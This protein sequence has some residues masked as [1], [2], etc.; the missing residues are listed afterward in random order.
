MKFAVLALLGAVS[1]INLEHYNDAQGLAQREPS[2]TTKADRDLEKAKK[3]V[4]EKASRPRE[5]G[6]S[7]NDPVHIGGT[8]GQREG[9]INE[10]APTGNPTGQFPPVTI[11][12][13]VETDSNNGWQYSTTNRFKIK[14]AMDGGR[15]LYMSYE[16]EVG[17]HGVHTNQYRVYLRESEGNM[18]EFWY[19]NKNDQTIRS[20]AN[21]EYCLDWDHVKS[22]LAN[23]VHAV[24]RPCSGNPS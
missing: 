9:K 3:A 24:A 20:T 16:P 23:N 1:A 8:G 22:S 2:E 4:A 11:G 6:M 7:S 14:S 10:P 15:V 13:T 21:G 17:P 19:Y 12:H 18:A 5:A